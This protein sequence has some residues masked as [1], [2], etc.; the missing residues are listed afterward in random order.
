M[1]R[2]ARGLAAGTLA[3]VLLGLCPGAAPAYAL[4]ADEARALVAERYRVEVLGI[5]AGTLDGRAVWVVT[6]MQPGGNSN[7]AFRVTRLAVDRESGALIPSFRHEGP[8]GY[9][10]PPAAGRETRTPVSPGRAAG[11]VWR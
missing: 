10:V 3:G 1:R 8:S 2:L 5:E 6:V 11:T 7:G 9:R 4:M